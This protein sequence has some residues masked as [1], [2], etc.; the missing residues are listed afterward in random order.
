MKTGIVR[1]ITQ[2]NF[3]CF[4]ITSTDSEKTNDYYW[5]EEVVSNIDIAETYKK[6]KPT[7]N[8][9]LLQQFKKCNMFIKL[10]LEARKEH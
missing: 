4:S 3:V 7:E 1:K 10:F 2:D 5:F 9:M 8:T 6:L